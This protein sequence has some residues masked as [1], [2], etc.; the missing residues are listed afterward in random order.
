MESTSK[1][2]LDRLIQQAV[3]RKVEA[4]VTRMLGSETF[5]SLDA[6]APD[7]DASADTA[8]ETPKRRGRPKANGANGTAKRTKVG[9]LQSEFDSA[10]PSG[11]Q[12]TIVMHDKGETR[13]TIRRKGDE[14]TLVKGPSVKC[15]TLK[16]TDGDRSTGEK[17][18]RFGTPIAD[19]TWRSASGMMEDLIV[20]IEIGRPMSRQVNGFKEFLARAVE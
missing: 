7:T 18:D 13:C 2:A 14:F 3:D 5:T 16:R 4:A 12:R 11:T 8:G 17:S 10:F 15:R 19:L 1:S 20:S 9:S 6:D